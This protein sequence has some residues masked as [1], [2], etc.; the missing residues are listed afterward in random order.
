MNLIIAKGLSSTTK[1]EI[2]HIASAGGRWAYLK[3][4]YLTLNHT[5]KVI[6]L[7]EMAN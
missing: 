1:Y 6:K 4:K 3:K 5:I 2:N 7:I